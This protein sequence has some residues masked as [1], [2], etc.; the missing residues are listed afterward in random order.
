MEILLRNNAEFF[1]WNNSDILLDYFL[2]NQRGFKLE[3]FLWKK[4][5]ITKERF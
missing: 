5:Q 4:F 1:A 3:I 2:G